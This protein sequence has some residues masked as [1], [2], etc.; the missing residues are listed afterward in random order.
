MAFTRALYYPWIEIRDEHW[1]RTACLYWDKICTIVPSSIERPY[2]SRVSKELLDAGILEPLR[3]N[4]DSPEIRAVEPDLATYLD[5]QEA[6]TLL[7]QGALARPKPQYDVDAYNR[8]RHLSRL[9]PDKA[10]EAMRR[11]FVGV[12]GWLHLD[13]E[14]THFYMTLLATRLA[15]NRGL[16][17]LTSSSSA[18]QLA[19]SARRGNLAYGP[20]VEQM[21]ETGRM[22]RPMI[23]GTMVD[24][25]LGGPIV[26][27]AV[28]IKK[29]VE[30]RR[31]HADELGRLRSE[32]GKLASSV[33]EGTS[34]QGIRQH[35]RD[36]VANEV[37]PA[38]NDL[39]AALKGNLAKNLSEGLLKASFLSAAPTSA[40]VVGGLA[41]PTALALGAGI[42]LVATGVMMATERDRIKRE[43]A[44]SYILSIER[45][46]G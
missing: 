7:Q 43:S 35:V 40:L 10:S 25:L 18:D 28:S 31:K 5:S 14:F 29:L 26:G 20:L 8:V 16:G 4:S 2:E 33:P 9:H 13:S 38:V 34:I 6:G 12:D 24:L 27:R 39:R 44:F 37:L 15:Q 41:V 42:S 21:R 17:L 11:E 30:F 19:N 45:Q 3:V 46:F 36:V 32:L 1:L 23:E 22:P